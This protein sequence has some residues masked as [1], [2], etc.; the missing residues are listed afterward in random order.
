MEEFMWLRCP[1]PDYSSPR[2]WWGGGGVTLTSTPILAFPYRKMEKRI[3]KLSP[4]NKLIYS[5][6]LSFI[7]T[8][9]GFCR[10]STTFLPSSKHAV[11]QAKSHLKGPSCC[12]IS[13]SLVNHLLRLH[14]EVFGSGS[15]ARA[16]ISHPPFPVGAIFK[17]PVGRDSY[18]VGFEGRQP[19]ETDDPKWVCIP[20][21]RKG[22]Y[23][24]KLISNQVSQE[25]CQ[26]E[27]WGED[28]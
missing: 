27:L 8:T 19:S 6:I 24:V 14:F 3:Q 2:R 16:Q 26:P 25:K 1:T 17:C 4:K 21:G 9:L 13:D 22:G 15:T 7:P 5:G 10:G 20:S 11:L 28:S 12:G 18:G 23:L